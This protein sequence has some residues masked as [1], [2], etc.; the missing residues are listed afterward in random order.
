M[1]FS[2]DQCNRYK[3]SYY[4]IN[5]SFFNTFRQPLKAPEKRNKKIVI[6]FPPEL[7]KN[8]NFQIKR[9]VYREMELAKN[10]GLF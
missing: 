5:G 10:Q 4:Y 3:R 2:Y 9:R 6:Q 8:K 1:S 7:F